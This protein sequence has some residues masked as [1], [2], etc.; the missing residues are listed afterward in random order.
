[1]RKLPLIATA[2]MAMLASPV[3]AKTV[4]LDKLDKGLDGWW[5]ALDVAC[6]GGGGGNATDLACDQR[7]ALDKII[8]KARVLEHL[9]S[10]R[11]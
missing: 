6:R 9:S 8:E 1:M 2:M 7:L 10:H 4:Y 5:N 11:P 3:M